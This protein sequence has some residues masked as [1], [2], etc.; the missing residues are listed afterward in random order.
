M[1]RS[2]FDS[3]SKRVDGKK[4]K[5]QETLVDV[6][7]DKA[8]YY[9]AK[10]LPIDIPSNWQLSIGLLNAVLITVVFFS[11]FLTSYY[12]TVKTVYLSPASGSTADQNC[13]LIPQSNTGTFLATKEGIWQSS[14]EF[15]FVDAAYS[16]S[17]T[18]LTITLDEYQTNFEYVY[19]ALINLGNVMIVQN[20][21]HNLL[22]W[23][24]VSFVQGASQRFTMT[25]TPLNV[26]NRQFHDASMGSVNG[27]C[28]ANS[29]T[30]FDISSGLVNI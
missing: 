26:F 12:Q 8:R 7:I 18:G 1:R 3:D 20:L 30:T 24:T 19:V 13:E 4:K 21:A 15:S 28:A 14:S 10:C 27:V 29:L 16:I 22:I 17:L 6:W 25:G 5:R 11:L 23:M 9:L 2:I